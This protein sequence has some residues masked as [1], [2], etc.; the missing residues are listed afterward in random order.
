MKKYLFA[1]IL[2][3]STMA[4]A[5]FKIDDL[6]KIGVKLASGKVNCNATYLVSQGGVFGPST[7]NQLVNIKGKNAGDA[8]V[9]AQS[10]ASKGGGV[11]GPNSRVL[12]SLQCTK[13]TG[14][15]FFVDINTC[16]PIK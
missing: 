14:Q 4:H 6:I 8:C 7:Q 2:V 9:K 13:V 16:Q 3:A 5:Q 10:M 12:R 11:F 1:A 15:S